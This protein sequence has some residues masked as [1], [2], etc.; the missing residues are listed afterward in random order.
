MANILYIA[1]LVLNYSAIAFALIHIWINVFS[2]ITD[3]DDRSKNILKIV[4]SSMYMSLIFSLATC[5]FIRSDN[6]AVAISR[7]TKLYSIIAIS[8]LV[9]V[10]SCGIAM[11]YLFI[12]K[13]TFKTSTMNSVKNIFKIAVIGAVL[14]LIL[15]WLL[16]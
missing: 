14:G 11:L 9:I 2:K 13:K 4:K 1:T 10:F 8:W 15:S 5:L 6:V 12:S 3:L 16:S 7:A